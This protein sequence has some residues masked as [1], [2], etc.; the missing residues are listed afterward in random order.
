METKTKYCLCCDEDVPY[1]VVIRNERRELTCTFCGFTLD[2]ENLWEEKK[3][4]SKTYALLA[5]DSPFTRKLLKGV[6]QKKAIATEVIDASN[7]LEFVSAYTKLMNEN[8]LPLFVI[9]DL[10]MPIMDGLTAARTIRALEEQKGIPKVPIVFFS[11]IKADDS[12]RKQMQLLAPANY[13][14][15]GTSSEPEKL[16]H[17]IEVLLN[18]IVQKYSKEV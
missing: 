5:E 15:K 1:N 13:I 8:I 3:S 11:S 4:K 17:R 9:L 7:G 12:L 6:I 16:A 2:V 14:N 18:F 10:N